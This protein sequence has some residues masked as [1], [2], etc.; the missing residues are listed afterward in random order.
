MMI[1]NMNIE[2]VTSK[3]KILTAVILLGYSAISCTSSKGIVYQNLKMQ[4]AKGSNTFSE[5][6]LVGEIEDTKIEHIA[7]V[8]PKQQ[9][10]NVSKEYVKMFLFIKG[11]GIFKADTSSFQIVPESMAAPLSGNKIEID[12]AE[13]DTLHF[14]SFTK[15]YTKEDYED[16]NTYAQQKRH[17]VFFTKFSDCI[18]YTEKI[19]S[20]KTVSR[21]V[22]PQDIIPRVALGTVQT[23]GPDEVGAHK[24]AML[25]Q[26]FLGLTDNDI[27]VHANDKSTRLGA[28]SLLHIPLG[29]SHWATVDEGKKMYYM[30]MDFFINREGQ[31]WL[32][33]HKPIATDKN[34]F[35][36]K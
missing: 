13:G 6:L 9:T 33:T 3:V 1:N 4:V 22:L 34:E 35:L 18:P 25:D 2:K 30:W 17:N 28:Y 21:T 16:L 12:I 15:K 27:I 14:V 24:H 8:G 32:K 5:K 26:L 11:N 20:P 19:K 31:I 23:T 7:Y 29:S 36:K 10:I